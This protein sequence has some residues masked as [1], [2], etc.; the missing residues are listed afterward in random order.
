VRVTGIIRASR[1]RADLTGK[2]DPELVP[3]QQEL[4]VWNFPNLSRIQLQ[5]SYPLLPVYI[6]ESNA[7]NKDSFPISTP[8]VVEIS[9]GPHLGYA[10]QWF[11]FAGI[12][13]FGYPFFI[14]KQTAISKQQTII[15]KDGS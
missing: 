10:L 5:M 4:Q 2:S 14:K 3:G 11:T 7:D 9:D 13:L 12:F 15:S 1:E 8:Y 6:Q